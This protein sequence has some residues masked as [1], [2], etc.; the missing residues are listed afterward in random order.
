M[1]PD[2]HFKPGLYEVT[3]NNQQ[4]HA[5]LFTDDLD[6]E[7]WY[8]VHIY[9]SVHAKEFVVIDSFDETNLDVWTN[10]NPRFLD[11]A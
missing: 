6:D 2:V 9:K 3:W 7:G 1:Q 11:G 8:E 10:L 5:D 4:H